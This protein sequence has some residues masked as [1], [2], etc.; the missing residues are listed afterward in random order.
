MPCVFWME[1]ANTG[2]SRRPHPG[3]HFSRYSAKIGNF[4]GESALFHLAVIA[5]TMNTV[6]MH[7]RKK[8]KRGMF[9]SRS[10][11]T[12]TPRRPLSVNSGTDDERLSGLC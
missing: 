7:F 1:L 3:P 6:L 9:R 4:R 12:R 10:R 2:E 5:F 8:R 11:S